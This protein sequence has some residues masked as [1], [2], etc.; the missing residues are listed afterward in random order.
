ME[1]TDLSDAL[2][3]TNP[4]ETLV[5]SITAKADTKQNVE[6]VMAA[7]GGGDDRFQTE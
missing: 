7:L 1:T 5:L 4:P 6:D 3:V 2:T